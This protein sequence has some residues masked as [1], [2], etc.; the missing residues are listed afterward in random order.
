MAMPGPCN[1]SICFPPPPIS[2][3]GSAHRKEF[4]C[5]SYAVGFDA[6]PARL[7]PDAQRLAYCLQV[8]EKDSPSTAQRSDAEETTLKYGLEAGLVKVWGDGGAVR[9]V[10]V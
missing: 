6:L 4:G 8:K 3:G 9:W 7:S 5:S 2:S 1:I 10:R